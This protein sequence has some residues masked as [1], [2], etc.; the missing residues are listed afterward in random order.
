MRENSND[1]K[2]SNF[3]YCLIFFK[4]VG[5]N[6]KN[7]ININIV[8]LKT[9][10]AYEVTVPV[11]ANDAPVKYSGMAISSPLAVTTVENHFF[12]NFTASVDNTFIGFQ[13]MT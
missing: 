5:A 4:P 3:N 7:I 11:L 12:T 10:G 13:A 2:L 6:P 1:L 8:L 9:V